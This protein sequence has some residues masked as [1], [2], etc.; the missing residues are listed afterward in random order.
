MDFY[1]EYKMI[2]MF[3]FTMPVLFESV[4]FGQLL[5]DLLYEMRNDYILVLY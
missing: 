4:K 2:T 3:L 5:F 1:S